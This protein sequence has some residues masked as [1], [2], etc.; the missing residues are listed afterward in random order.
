MNP[1]A[2]RTGPRLVLE[3]RSGAPN[4]VAVETAFELARA[5]RSE[6]DAIFIEDQDLM[7]AAELSCAREIALVSGRR[8]AISPGRMARDMR[9]ITGAIRRRMEQMARANEVP[10]RFDVVR[11]HP[12]QAVATA[13]REG[14]F[15]AMTEPYSSRSAQE[16]AELARAHANVAGFVLVG[17]RVRTVTGPIVVAIE[18]T[19]D[20]EQLVETAANVGS[21]NGSLAI[22]VIGEDES[23]IKTLGVAVRERLTAAPETRIMLCGAHGEPAVVAEAAHRLRGRLLIAR[24][25]GMFRPNQGTLRQLLAALECPLLLMR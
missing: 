23:E 3:V 22:L 21:S 15:V 24:M 14:A 20:L 19:S 12:A 13:T 5:L 10:H 17:P 8:A 4:R 9:M 18:S 25:S 2:R 6:I 7:A 1:Q 16:I 11:E